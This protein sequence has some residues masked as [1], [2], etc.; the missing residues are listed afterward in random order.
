MLVLAE[1]LKKKDS[2]KQLYKPNTENIY[3]L[4]EN[5][6]LLLK[7][8]LKLQMISLCIGFLKKMEIK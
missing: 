4:M 1:R 5:K 7:R 3:F 2:P 8:G 6:Y